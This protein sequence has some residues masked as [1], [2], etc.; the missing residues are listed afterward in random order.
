MLMVGGAIMGTYS[1]GIDPFNEDVQ[2]DL[3]VSGSATIGTAI[4]FGTTLSMANTGRIVMANGTVGAPSVVFFSSQTTGLYR[5]AGAIG[6]AVGGTKIVAVTGSGVQF[7]SAGGL[8][9]DGGTLYISMAGDTGPNVGG[10]VYAYG[11]SHLTH[12][13]EVN[14][15][16]VNTIRAAF[17]AGGATLTGAV[18]VGG[19]LATATGGTSTIQIITSGSGGTK[20][21]HL[22]DTSNTRKSWLVGAQN[23][24]S[25]AFEINY[26]TTAGG[27]DWQTAPAIVISAAGVITAANLGGTGSRAVVADANGVLSAPVSDY[28]LK[29]KINPIHTQ[30]DPVDALMKLK[31]VFFNWDTSK[32]RVKGHGSQREI[33]MLAQ[34]VEAVIPEAVREDKDGWKSL[35]Y[36]HLVPLLIEVVKH[37]QLEIRDLQ[38]RV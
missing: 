34:D 25:D 36:G 3:T 4:S 31:G 6:M 26:S 17:G 11:S 7:T 19:I 33:G 16:A 37:Q 22:I 10:A 2:G 28:R 14:V 20:A 29:T 1:P 21:L 18:T 30:I 8:S 32:D 35:D 9:T 23:K 13:G 24:V 38:R 27:Q 5:N 12:P 15:V